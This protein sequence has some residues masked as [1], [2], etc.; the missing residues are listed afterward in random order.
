M[1]VSP[2]CLSQSVPNAAQA[3]HMLSSLLLVYP[4]VGAARLVKG[5]S[6][7]VLK[8]YARRLLS[9]A[10]F[11]HLAED[12]RQAFAI[13]ELVHAEPGPLRGIYRSAT[14]FGTDQSEVLTTRSEGEV[15]DSNFEVCDVDRRVLDRLHPH[16]FREYWHGLTE[17]V[18]C[19]T[20]EL[21]VALLTREAIELLVTLVA[22]SWGARLVVAANVGIDDE[23]MLYE[24]DSLNAC[25]E[26]LKQELVYN[27]QGAESADLWAYHDEVRVV[28]NVGPSEQ[29]SPERD[30]T[31][32]EK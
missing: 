3:V 29:D 30:V 17:A 18:E 14:Q 10:Q 2:T 19:V 16:N 1:P 5:H 4:G 23:R 11:Q 22:D 21:D 9:E 31:D 15:G 12:V 20:V 24:S 26:V 25:L 13:W 6:V 8:F 32:A 28:V 7:L 27:K